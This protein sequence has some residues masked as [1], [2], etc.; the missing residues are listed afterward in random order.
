MLNPY[1]PIKAKDGIPGWEQID[2]IVEEWQPDIMVVGLPLN[3]D[4]TPQHVTFAAKKI[5]QPTQQS[6][7]YASSHS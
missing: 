5:R 3:M 6:L 7:S 1:K 2:T 4:G